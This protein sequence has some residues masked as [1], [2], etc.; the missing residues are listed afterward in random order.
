MSAAGA[1]GGRPCLVK[2]L[3]VP[4]PAL[5]G[6]GGEGGSRAGLRTPRG[7]QPPGVTRKIVHAK[8]L[9]ALFILTRR[10]RSRWRGGGSARPARG[11]GGPPP[12]RAV[13]NACPIRH[14]AATRLRSTPR[15]I[16]E[17][18]PDRGRPLKACPPDQLRAAP[19]Q[20]DN[21]LDSGAGDSAAP[22]P[23]KCF[24]A[25]WL[26]RDREE[27]TA[28]RIDTAIPRSPRRYPNAINGIRWSATRCCW[29]GEKL[30]AEGHCRG[31]AGGQ[32]RD[33]DAG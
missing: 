3:P 20:T 11:A 14:F 13:F 2:R 8:E 7:E 19:T 1:R 24:K 28:S 21:G 15:P 32:S 6:G 12:I 23:L 22:G 5:R 4:Y 10:R 9:V 18:R 17:G 27:E 25:L 30:G 16:A 33:R 29:R 26:S 31:A